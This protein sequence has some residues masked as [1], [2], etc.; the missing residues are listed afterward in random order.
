MFW[1]LIEFIW[2]VIKFIT[3][4]VLALPL[5]LALVMH[6]LQHDDGQLTSQDI[7]LHAIRS[8]LL[9]HLVW[10]FRELLRFLLRVALY[11]SIPV[12]LAAVSYLWGGN[13]L[14]LRALKGP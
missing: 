4:G 13:V 14:P 7:F 12:G 3:G 5:D 11:G 1:S 6:E 9:W 2:S 8:Y 10:N